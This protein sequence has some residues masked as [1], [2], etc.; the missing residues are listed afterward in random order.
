[1][2]NHPK[3]E[4]TMTL[5]CGIDLHSTNSVLSIVNEND[6]V[7]FEQR[8]PNDLECIRAA[9]GPYRGELAGC[10]VE[11]TYNGYW[12]VDGPQEAGFPMILARNYSLPSA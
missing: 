3:E 11:S 4:S 6:E 5:Y 8:L 1:M 9:L 12:L 2:T 10:A 7:V